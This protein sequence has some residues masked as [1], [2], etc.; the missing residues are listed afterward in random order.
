MRI[1]YT[2]T[3]DYD[4]KKVLSVLKGKMRISSRLINRLKTSNGILLN[5]EPIR[6]IDY[7]HTGDT[8]SVII[9]FVE[10]TDIEPEDR[11]LSILYE[12]DSF[13]A[14]D[15][16]PNTLVHPTTKQATGTLAHFVMAHFSKQGLAIK[17]RP[18]NRLD[19]DTSGIVLFAKNPYVQEQ[20]IWQMKN[21]KVLKSYLGIVHGTFETEEGKIDL[22]IARKESSIIE[23]V[24]DD[25]GDEAV[26]R[27]KTL[28][29]FND[30][31]LVQFILETGRTHQIRVH[32]SAMGHPII[33]DWLYS[34]TSTNLIERQALHAHILAFDHP[35]T[36]E[37]I[38][39]TAP[40]PEDI[41]RVLANKQIP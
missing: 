15:K 34:N 2:V 26:T 11:P 1:D 14:V 6:T 13:L 39:I 16:G 23:R 33:G 29:K 21:N 9:D 30:Y 20:I 25:S 10:E 35:I 32:S 40:I 36:G 18:I 28:E 3:E 17:I 19:K 24:I 31:S 22:P 8:V 4:N 12:D 5:N 7:M 38:T 41:K 27:Y 37:R